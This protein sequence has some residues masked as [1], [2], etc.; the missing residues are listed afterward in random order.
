VTKRNHFKV[1]ATLLRQFLDAA[2]GVFYI[3]HKQRN[4]VAQRVV[5]VGQR[6]ARL[7]HVV[8]HPIYAI[9]LPIA[10]VCSIMKV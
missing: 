6:I 7:Q 5:A 1:V 2:L 10:I 8:L 4:R 3:R 9:I